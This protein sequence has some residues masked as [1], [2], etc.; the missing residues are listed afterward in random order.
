MLFCCRLM[1]L[2]GKSPG[3]HHSSAH[4]CIMC[5]S[6]ALPGYRESVHPHYFKQHPTRTSRRG[7]SYIC[8]YIHS[9][10]VILKVP[11][12]LVKTIFIICFVVHAVYVA[13]NSFTDKIYFINIPLLGLLCFFNIYIWFLDAL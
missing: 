7:V 2:T 3:Q 13:V 8:P 6:S 1:I 4:Y 11:F 10:F 5:G 12:I 9:L